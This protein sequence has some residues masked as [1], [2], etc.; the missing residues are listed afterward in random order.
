MVDLRR[1]FRPLFPRRPGGLS[2]EAGLKSSRFGA[3]EIGASF[4]FQS[5]NKVN[6]SAFSRIQTT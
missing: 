5:S 4:E 2:G 3:A 6:I 1:S